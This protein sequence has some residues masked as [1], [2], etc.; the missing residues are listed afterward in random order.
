MLG[1]T[2]CEEVLNVLRSENMD[3]IP[4]VDDDGQLQ[5]MAQV[6]FLVNKILDL[7]LNPSDA[8]EKALYKKFIKVT[9][10]TSVGRLS[11]ILEKEAY[12]VVVDKKTGVVN[13]EL[14]EA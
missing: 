2:P 3:Q 10:D 13:G 1:S 5:G 11:R 7:T 6:N 12:V 4:I 8:I 14:C 9:S